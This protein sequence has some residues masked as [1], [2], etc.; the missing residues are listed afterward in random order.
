MD[1]YVYA[2]FCADDG[3]L[4][5]V[6][7]GS[8]R[9]AWSR[10]SRN[11]HWKSVV[12]K[13]GRRVRLLRSGLSEAEAFRIEALLIAARK[14][15][16]ATY[17]AGGRGIAGYR[18]TERAKAA[19][20]EK[21]TG[22][23]MSE[24]ARAAM[25]ATIRSRP[26]LLALRAETFAGD[27]NPAR[28]TQ[29]RAASSERMTHAN[30]MQRAE[31]REKMAASKRGQTLSDEARKKIGNALRGRKRGPMPPQVA[32]VLRAVRETRKRP[33]T[34]S[35]GLW[36]FSTAEAARATGARQGGIVNN[37]AGR[38]KSAGGFQWSYSNEK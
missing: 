26:D 25:S 8:G 15:R 35:C 3:R 30:P 20:S 10:S 5:Y 27:R 36:F 4:F 19:M 6:G 9:R 11:R 22:R 16:L 38:A 28:K 34:T 18:H 14:E 37:C 33:V 17:T 31:V 7:K 32:E 29:N 13:H 23:K 21:R 2:H 1:F 12:A 24:A